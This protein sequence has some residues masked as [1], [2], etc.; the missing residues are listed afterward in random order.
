MKPLAA[1]LVVAAALTAVGMLDA[2][3]ATEQQSSCSRRGF[4]FP[5]G[6]P[7]EWKP[8]A[9]FKHPVRG[10]AGEPVAV[11]GRTLVFSGVT[12]I[13]G[14]RRHGLAAIDMRSGRVLPFAPVL[15]S[16]HFVVALAASPTTVYAAHGPEGSGLE[17]DAYRLSTGA[18]VASFVPPDFRNGHAYSLVYAGGSVIVG[19]A[20]DDSRVTL[21]AY[22]PVTGAPR[23]RQELEWRVDEMVTDGSRL[24]IAIPPGSPG[25]RPIGAYDVKSGK[26]VAGWGASLPARKQQLFLHGVDAT[27]VFGTYIHGPVIAKLKDGSRATLPQLPPRSEPRGG[28]ARTIVGRIKIRGILVG[29]VFSPTGKLIGTACTTNQVIAQ[30]DDTHLIADQRGGSQTSS[31]IVELAAP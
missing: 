21:G 31:H 16:G 28:T 5:G 17:V 12:S 23:W 20:Q 14:K 19:G 29:A 30:V 25:Y 11:T 6:G 24:Y 13:A 8:T 9:K 1:A 10:F 7:L 2:V 3:P 27:R 18:P 15:P 4:V 26:R 22:H